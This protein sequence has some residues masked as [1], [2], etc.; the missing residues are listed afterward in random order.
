MA[1]TVDKLAGV[2]PTL[3]EKI[4]RVLAHM[5]SIGSPM[6]VVQGVRTDA[7]QKALYALGRTKPGNKVTNADGVTHKSNHQLKDDGWGYAVDC[8][9]QDHVT[10]VSWEGPWD[11]Y[12]AACRAEGLHWGGDWKKF[13]DRPHAEL[14]L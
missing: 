11:E 1:A 13:P 10:K 8:A 4:Q 5:A 14:V 3:V 9:F 6:I 2:H 7:E 12:G